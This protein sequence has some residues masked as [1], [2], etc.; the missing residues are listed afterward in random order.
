ML[1]RGVLKA[2][3]STPKEMLYLELGII[4]PFKETIMR[5]KKIL[6]FYYIFNQD[7]NA[8]KRTKQHAMKNFWTHKSILVRVNKK[9][10][11]HTVAVW[12]N[13]DRASSP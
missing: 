6:F 8:A 1:L 11:T 10:S 3:K 2:P 5:R 13:L 7:K 9:T 4:T 12:D